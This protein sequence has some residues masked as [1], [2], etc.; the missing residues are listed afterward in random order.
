M[1]IEEVSPS[2]YSAIIREPFHRFGG[3]EF[4]ELNAHKAARVYYLLFKDTRYRLGIIAAIDDGTFVSPFSA[5]FGGFS[6]VYDDVR[7]QAIEESVAELETW[8]RARRINEIRYTLPPPIYQERFI[9]K[10]TNVMYRARYTISTMELNFHF[11]LSKLTEDY[12]RHLWRNARKNLAVALAN[13]LHFL[14]CET[15]EQK[16]IAYA[17]IKRNRLIRG[18]PL[19]MTLESVLE[20][21]AIL[22]ADFFLVRKVDMTPLAGAVVFSVSPEIAQV[23]YWGDDPDFQQLKTMNYLS[24]KIFEYYRDRNFRILDIGYSTEQSIPNYG[25]CEFKESIGCDIQPKLTFSKLL[26]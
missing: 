15:E 11:D 5:P 3:A 6:F 19:R 25:L 12:S 24:F 17:M 7:I 9:A 16:A 14:R 1:T 18:K 23:I 21:A 20:T 4:N 22:P 26:Q 10:L 8:C 2:L 13:D